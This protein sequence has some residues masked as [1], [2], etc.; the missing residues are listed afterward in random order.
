M[1]A[2]PSP[3]CR[4]IATHLGHRLRPNAPAHRARRAGCVHRALLRRTAAADS[5]SRLRASLVTTAPPAPDH[6]PRRSVS[7]TIAPRCAPHPPPMPAAPNSCVAAPLRPRIAPS[8]HLWLDQPASPWPCP[9]PSGGRR[10]R[11]R[12]RRLP[13]SIWA[14]A[15]SGWAPAPVTHTPAKATVPMTS[16]PRPRTVFKKGDKKI[17][18][19]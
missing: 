10:R 6:C 18:I 2:T 9:C 5:S 12:G 17:I 14:Y 15:Q 16:G 8:P 11:V 19:I 1:T 13:P 3:P 4:S 7:L